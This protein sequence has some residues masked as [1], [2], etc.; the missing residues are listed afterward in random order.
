[1]FGIVTLD[2]ETRRRTFTL[3]K[4]RKKS[5]LWS[6]SEA[7]PTYRVMGDKYVVL[8]VPAEPLQEGFIPS[9]KLCQHMEAQERAAAE[10]Q[11]STRENRLEVAG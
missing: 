8:N 2:P 6:G 11:A 9:H 10:E 4:R 3:R 5:A 7:E 1:M